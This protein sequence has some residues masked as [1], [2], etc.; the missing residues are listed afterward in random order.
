MSIISISRDFLTIIFIMLLFLS[1]IQSRVEEKSRQPSNHSNR[2]FTKLKCNFNICATDISTA[3]SSS[4]TCKEY[5]LIVPET[6]VP[7]SK[8]IQTTQQSQVA[9]KGQQ[10]QSR[11]QP[12]SFL[13]VG[14]QQAGP[15]RPLIFTLTQRKQFNNRQRKST[16]NIWT[17]RILWES[18][19]S[20]VL[21]IDSA[22]C[23]RFHHPTCEP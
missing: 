3:T 18:T 21:P 22:H 23:S 8:V 16:P 12:T 5:I 20:A 6:H 14:D 19:L 1:S 9:T 11:L 10:Q 13:E 15:L 7:A 2:H 4:T 17:L